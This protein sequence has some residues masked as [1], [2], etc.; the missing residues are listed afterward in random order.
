[1]RLEIACSLYHTRRF[2]KMTSKSEKS[3]VWV[4]IYRLYSQEW[5]E[6]YYESV[7]I[8]NGSK[9][10]WNRPFDH[11]TIEL[12]GTR[13]CC[14]SGL[15]GLFNIGKIHSNHTFLEPQEQS[16]QT[17]LR[18]TTHALS[19]SYNGHFWGSVAIWK[20]NK[21]QIILYWSETS[22]CNAY[23]AWCKLKLQ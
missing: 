5:L 23:W 19:G 21:F 12:N 3:T 13:R 1:M 20:G 4:W 14:C 10:Y 16:W 18:K 2:K 8:Y 22:L 9:Y 6:F 15:T 11:L 7:T 17:V